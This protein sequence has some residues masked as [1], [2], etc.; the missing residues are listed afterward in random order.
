[1]GTDTVTRKNRMHV[2][3]PI[4]WLVL[5]G[6]VAAGSVM[7][8]DYLATAVSSASAHMLSDGGSPTIPC[9]TCG[10]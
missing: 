1:M 8:S 3:L 4:A 9:G 7:G 5:A 10:H 6:S 2:L